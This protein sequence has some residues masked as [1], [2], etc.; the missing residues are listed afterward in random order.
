MKRQREAL[1]LSDRDGS[2][3]TIESGGTPNRIVGFSFYPDVSDD[4]QFAPSLENKFAPSES[5]SKENADPWTR[6]CSHA[7]MAV[8]DAKATH[9]WIRGKGKGSTSRLAKG[10]K[11]TIKCCGSCQ[12][13]P[14]Q[15]C[16]YISID[17]PSLLL[18]AFFYF[19]WY[20]F[21]LSTLSTLL[22]K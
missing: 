5:P 17:V 1:A 12:G 20:L 11:S 4:P 8:A 13:C 10:V 9:N 15:V 21:R 3:G 6:V 7:S 14:A 19:L 2:G 22:E 16:H 18:I